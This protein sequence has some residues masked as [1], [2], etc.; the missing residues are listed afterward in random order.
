VIKDGKLMTPPSSSSILQGITRDTVLKLAETW[1][2]PIV[3]QA[4]PR[5]ALYLADEIFMTGTAAEITP[6]RSVDG[7]EVRCGGRGPITHKVQQAFHGLFNGT[8]EDRWGWLEPVHSD[9]HAASSPKQAA[10]AD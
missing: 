2:V 10:L 3:E 6:I 7:I 9:G 8:T 1:S 5:E 4:M